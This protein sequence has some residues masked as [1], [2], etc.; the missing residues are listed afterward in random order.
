MTKKKGVRRGRRAGSSS[1]GTKVS[2]CSCRFA[3]AVLREPGCSACGAVRRRRS[4][5]PAHGAA[6]RAPRSDPSGLPLPRFVSLKSGKVNSRIGPGVNYPVDWLYLKPGLPME[7][8]QEYRQLAARAR[9]R[10]CRGLDQP[11]AAVWASARR[12]TP[13][14]S[15]AR[16]QLNLLAPS[17]AERRAHCRHHRAGGGRLDQA[18]QR[19]MVPDVVSGTAAGSSQSQVWGAYPGESIEN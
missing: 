14:G 2:A 19:H 13:R 11:V 18:V 9:C 12:S 7:I 15:A 4:P 10:R 1:R 3:S 8:I 5:W 6:A 17:R 16:A